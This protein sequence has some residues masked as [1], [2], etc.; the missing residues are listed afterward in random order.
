MR[1]RFN[2]EIDYL[3]LSIT[4]KC[5]LRCVYCMEDKEQD[6]LKNS[7]LMTNEE[8][9]RIV[10]ASAKL[11]IKK[12]R[13]TGGEPLA[14]PK[15]S[16]LME[17]LNQIDGID[18]I[19]MTTNGTLFADQVHLFAKHGLKGVNIS[20]DTLKEDR[21]KQITRRGS[22]SDV[23]QFIDECLKHELKVKINTVL[24]DGVNDDEILDFV[25][26]TLTHPI[27]VRFIELMPIGI[28]KNHKG[29]SNTKILEMIQSNHFEIEESGR[30]KKGG[31]AEYIK[32]NGGLGRVGFISAVS[33]CF[34]QDCNRIRVTADGFLKQC[35]HFRFGVNLKDHLREGISDE[36][37]VR[38]ISQNIYEKPE[39]HL[40]NQKDKNEEIKL[41]NQIGG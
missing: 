18:E 20:L 37:L 36:E 10:R 23:L 5:N 31:P 4:D 3:R 13:L 27:D 15:V 33:N 9:I 25:K 16:E 39:K 40:F 30:A 35:L 24:M 14:R 32:I 34:C 22:L 41:M 8:I 6:F 29:V 28:G 12:I 17:Q 1:D 26:L 38:L 21:F 2:R 7:H 19:Y 11:G